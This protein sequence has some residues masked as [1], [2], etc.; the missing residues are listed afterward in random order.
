MLYKVDDAM[1]V[2]SLAAQVIGHLGESIPYR[3]DCSRELIL[4][5]EQPAQPVVH[6]DIIGRKKQ[7]AASIHFLLGQ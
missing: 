2:L 1:Q 5:R 4:Y 7:F 3:D 6:A